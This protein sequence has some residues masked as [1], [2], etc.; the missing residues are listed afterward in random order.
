MQTGET[1]SSRDRNINWMDSS[2]WINSE[3]YFKQN[4]QLLLKYIPGMGVLKTTISKLN[5]IQ[6]QYPT[7]YQQYH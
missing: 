5:V 6:E 2:K 3:K 1:N 4:R 7:Y